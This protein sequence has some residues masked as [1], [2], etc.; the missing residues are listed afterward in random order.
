M[1]LGAHRIRARV[2]R[3]ERLELLADRVVSAAVVR[4]A[5]VGAVAALLIREPA[6]VLTGRITAG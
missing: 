5:T 2:L 3:A 1:G 6:V 4:P